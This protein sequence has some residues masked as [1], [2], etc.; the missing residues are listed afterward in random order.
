MFGR[1]IR[2]EANRLGLQP[3]AEAA[4]A[5]MET[6]FRLLQRWNRRINL[7]AIRDDRGIVRRHFLESIQAAPVLESPGKILDFGSGNGFPGIPLALLRPHLSLQVVD[8]SEKKCSFLK[9]LFGALGWDTRGVVRRRVDGAADLHDLD[10]LQYITVRAVRL[11]RKLVD[12]LIG[13]LAPGGALILFAGDKDE[14]E[15]GAGESIPLAGRD[16]ARILVIRP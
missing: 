4:L 14:E 1:L 3:P 6:H 8:S 15:W 12:G 11:E 10:A 7:T 16:R 2:E 9:E 13:L 5:G